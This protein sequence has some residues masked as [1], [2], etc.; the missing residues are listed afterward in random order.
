MNPL[1]LNDL[2][3]AV[4]AW[5]PVADQGQRGSRSISLQ[6]SALADDLVDLVAERKFPE[7]EPLYRRLQRILD[8]FVAQRGLEIEDTAGCVAGQLRAFT[9][10][11]G[12]VSQRMPRTFELLARQ[13]LQLPVYRPLFE[14][15]FDGEATTTQLAQTIGETKETVS[16][17]LGVL[18]NLGLV[19]SHSL[20]R[21]VYS[22]LSPA[23]R[24]IYEALKRERVGAGSVASSPTKGG[25]S[26]VPPRLSL[27]P[28]T[29]NKF[30]MTELA[31]RGL[32]W[33]L[34]V[35]DAA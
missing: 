29:L 15:L 14:V 20:G 18:R 4:L 35:K 6:L 13:H 7:A 8:G 25:V 28:A 5:E 26:V 2:E 1:S 34:P 17:K 10:I 9:L 3:T 30:K 31:Q 16:R 11:L 33:E 21:N 32:D 12:V 23:A 19:M 24:E 27:A 22:E